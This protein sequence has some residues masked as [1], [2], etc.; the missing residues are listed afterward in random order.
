LEGRFDEIPVGGPL[1]LMV[2]Y[3]LCHFGIQSFCGDYE[4]DLLM[5]FSADL[6]QAAFAA[7]GAT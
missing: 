3:A 7:A 4:R 5:S 1:R 2:R 6:G